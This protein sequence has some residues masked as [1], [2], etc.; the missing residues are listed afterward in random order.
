VALITGASG[1]GRILAPMPPPPGTGLGPYFWMILAG[2]YAR[3]RDLW[4][5]PGVIPA[6]LFYLTEGQCVIE[7]RDG[8]FGM[9]DIE[10][11]F[12]ERLGA[13]KA[14]ETLIDY[15]RAE[16]ADQNMPMLA[17]LLRMAHEELTRSVLEQREGEQAV[18]LSS[19]YNDGLRRH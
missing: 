5:I 7:R 4:R 18:S 16:A 6:G 14:L 2:D 15:A 17:H 8:L 3:H 1:L 11:S 13:M 19:E 12:S 9:S 10:Q